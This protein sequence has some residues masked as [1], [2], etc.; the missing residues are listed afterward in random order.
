MSKSFI[1]FDTDKIKDDIM[2]QIKKNS[3]EIS[4]P[5]ECHGCGKEFEAYK[6]LN[7]C[8]HCGAQTSLDFDF[9]F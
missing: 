8:P 9:D 4:V 2:D 7:T 1:E 6:G 3:S 5:I